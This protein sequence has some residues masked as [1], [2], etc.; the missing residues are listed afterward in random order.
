MTRIL[1]IDDDALIL[2]ITSLVLTKLGYQVS[3]AADGLQGLNLANS[4]KP[5]VIIV[6]VL[7]PDINGYEITRRL[8]R[9]P[10]HAKTPIMILTSHTEL[11]DKLRAFEAGADDYMSKPFEPAELA[12]RI[13]KLLRW[14]EVIVKQKDVK[15]GE[16]EKGRFIAVH[17][18]RGGIGCSSIAVNL[19]L[20]LW[21]LWQR[22]TVLLDLVLTAGQVALML[23]SSLK[24]TWADLTRFNPDEIDFDLVKTI[25]GQHNSGL[26]IIAAPTFPE[27]AGNLSEELI[28]ASLNQIRPHFEYGVMDLAHDFSDSSLYGLDNAD[29]ILLLLAPD[30]SSVRAAAAA[31]DTYKKLGYADEKIKLIMNHT[32]QYHGLSRSAIE[33]ALHA[34][35]A[36]SIPFASDRFIPAINHG[37]PIFEFRPDD[38][39][40]GLLEDFAFGISK[41][42]HRNEKP[43][44][45]NEALRRVYKRIANR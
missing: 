23:N 6:D 11:E 3:V 20:C 27:Q 33:E 17:S 13:S 19:A 9:N 40:A 8:R 22:P 26:Q 37:I 43:E 39:I 42:K 4:E 10:I 21:G 36:L 44:N 12:A 16:E 1:V 29:L 2:K 18:L 35:I 45:Q 32:F 38:P 15:G 5:D 24:R 30:M 7:I 25:I 28:K 14:K 31:L 41:E 34:K